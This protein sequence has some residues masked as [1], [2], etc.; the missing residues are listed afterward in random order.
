[1]E[2]GV[3]SLE[4]RQ[5]A[6]RERLEILLGTVETDPK[7]PENRP[8]IYNYNPTLDPN[9][10]TVIAAEECSGEGEGPV[11]NPQRRGSRNGRRRAWCTASARTSW[12]GSHRS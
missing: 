7:G 2:A 10:D 11:P 8:H 4:R 6:A 1:M 3:T 5:H 9:K 12:R